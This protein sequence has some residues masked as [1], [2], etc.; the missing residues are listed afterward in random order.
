MNA[1]T[2]T[3]TSNTE[4]EAILKMKAEME[5]LRAENEKLRV[6]S[7]KANTKSNGGFRVSKKGAISVYGLGRFPVTLYQEQWV[8]LF[9]KEAKLKAFITKAGEYLA[10]REKDVEHTDEQLASIN[11]KL[12]E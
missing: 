3:Q 2:K 10:T 11:K 1:V 8:A 7:L 9:E 12:S 5:A 6:E 4:V